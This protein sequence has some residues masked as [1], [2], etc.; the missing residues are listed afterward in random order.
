[1]T[2]SRWRELTYLAVIMI[3]GVA[4][5]LYLSYSHERPVEK[6]DYQYLDTFANRY[7]A[8]RAAI[9]EAIKDDGKIDDVELE[10]IY[11]VLEVAQAEEQIRLKKEYS[12]AV[13][14]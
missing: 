7:P 3:F 2:F 8:V 10:R 1:M 11:E 4:T 14:R 13:N 9:Y 6:V 5:G 12:R